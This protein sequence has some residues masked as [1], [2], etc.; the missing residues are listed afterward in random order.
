VDGIVG[1]SQCLIFPLLKLLSGFADAGDSVDT[2]SV[3]CMY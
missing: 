3:H 2:G 1:E